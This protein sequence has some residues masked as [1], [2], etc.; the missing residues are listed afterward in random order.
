MHPRILRSFTRSNRANYLNS[1]DIIF[2]G[3]RNNPI[4]FANSRNLPS[5]LD[6]ALAHLESR[7]KVPRRYTS[8]INRNAGSSLGVG[9][10]PACPLLRHKLPS[11]S[12][13][14]RG[15]TDLSISLA[16]LFI[17][18]K[19]YFYR[20]IFRDLRDEMFLA[21]DPSKTHRTAGCRRVNSNIGP[22]YRPTRGTLR[23]LGYLNN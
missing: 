19:S 2:S 22:Q 12:A 10:A 11:P 4:N 21:S 6:S 20:L 5:S 18:W 8:V 9:S 3:K 1:K 14:G 17:A 15:I 13:T 23:D 16:N 7:T